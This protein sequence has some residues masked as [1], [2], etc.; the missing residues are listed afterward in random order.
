MSSK[1]PILTLQARWQRI[2]WVQAQTLNRKLLHLT[3]AVLKTFEPDSHQ[4]ITSGNLVAF[5]FW[6]TSTLLKCPLILQTFHEKNTKDFGS[7]LMFASSV[8][9][10]WDVLYYISMHNFPESRILAKLW[11]NG[12]SCCQQSNGLA[13][14]IV[15][16]AARRRRWPAAAAHHSET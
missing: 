11:L 9:Y 5:I 3:E 4:I 12:F 7:R 15:L 2:A 6:Q 1:R 13:C 8:V 10:P 16:K 14:L